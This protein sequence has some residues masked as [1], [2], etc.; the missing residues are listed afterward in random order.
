MWPP[1]INFISDIRILLYGDWVFSLYDSEQLLSPFGLS[2]ESVWNFLLS[3]SYSWE[4]PRFSRK[5]LKLIYLVK[6]LI[7]PICPAIGHWD[8]WNWI[9]IK[10]STL[11]NITGILI[12][13]GICSK[14]GILIIL[15]HKQLFACVSYR[16]CY[17]RHCWSLIDHILR[18]VFFNI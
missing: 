4:C 12:S 13:L 15:L 10:V 6:S 3:S 2:Q 16:G 5:I 18:D 11:S 9:M 7:R 14:L 17:S 1:N 8:T